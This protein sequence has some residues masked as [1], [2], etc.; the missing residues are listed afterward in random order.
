MKCGVQAWHS[1]KLGSS[2]SSTNSEEATQIRTLRGAI[3]AS[4]SSLRTGAMMACSEVIDALG[5]TALLTCQPAELAAVAKGVMSADEVD[6]LASLGD[7]AAL[8]AP[9]ERLAA[10]QR[11]ALQRARETAER[12]RAVLQT[13]VPGV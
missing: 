4:Q 10:A 3:A 12:H 5:D 11:D 8:L 2:G 13:L 6:V 7:P 9:I 1:A